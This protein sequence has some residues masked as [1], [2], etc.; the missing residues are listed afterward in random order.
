[1]ETPKQDKASESGTILKL[2]YFPLKEGYAYAQLSTSLSG[3]QYQALTGV[4][5][6]QEL[7]ESKK[8]GRSVVLCLDK[9]GSMAGR[10]FEALKQGAEMVGQQIFEKDEFQ[11]FMTV[12]YDEKAEAFKS[13]NFN[14]Y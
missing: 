11:F 10:A 14:D 3:S 12:F 1:M 9:S 4:M 13:P 8:K 7:I 5:P 6:G 2:R